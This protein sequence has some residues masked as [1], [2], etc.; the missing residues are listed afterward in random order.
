MITLLFKIYFLC[1]SPINVNN[2][3]YKV[4]TEIHFCIKLF[5]LLR[6]WLDWLTRE[7]LYL[8]VLIEFQWSLE[9]NHPV[10]AHETVIAFVGF[11]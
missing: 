6:I 9:I 1:Q 5:L 8:H 7:Y 3:Q 2:Y 4:D 10:S 11:C